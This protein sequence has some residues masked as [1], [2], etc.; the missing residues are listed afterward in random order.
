MGTG[1]L[2]RPAVSSSLTVIVIPK[3]ER[4]EESA[5]ALYAQTSD[6]SLRSG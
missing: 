4:G 1:G 3:S 6:L 5:V 2:A